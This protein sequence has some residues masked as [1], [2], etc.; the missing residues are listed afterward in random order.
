MSTGALGGQRPQSP[1]ELSRVGSENR[2]EE[3]YTL[4]RGAISPA[5]TP[6]I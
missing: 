1:L 2:S 5:P 6:F 4:N 3:Y